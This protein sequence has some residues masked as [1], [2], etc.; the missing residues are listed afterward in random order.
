MAFS[1]FLTSWNR[2]IK[3]ILRPKGGGRKGT[4][5][6]QVVKKKKSENGKSNEESYAV[7]FTTHAQARRESQFT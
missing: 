5:E 3:C 7:K 4:N 6:P 1:F 2:R